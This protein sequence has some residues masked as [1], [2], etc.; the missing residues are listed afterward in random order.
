MSTEQNPLN[1]LTVTATPG[2]EVSVFSDPQLAKA[3]AE[4]E[5]LPTQEYLAEMREFL[6][7]NLANNADIV[8]VIQD[9]REHVRIIGGSIVR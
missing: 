3:L 4:A 5:G 9:A 8:Q 2:E 1:D 6:K 7:K